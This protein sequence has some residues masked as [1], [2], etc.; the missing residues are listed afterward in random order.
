MSFVKYFLLT[1]LCVCALDAKADRIKSALKQLEKKEFKKVRESLDK[2]FE[3]D[4]SSAGASY[5]YAVFFV[6]NEN[7]AYNIDSAYF[8]INQAILFYPNTEEK[9]IEDWDKININDSSLNAQKLYI[10]KLAFQKAMKEN[11]VE[12]FQYFINNYS[13]ALQKNKAIEKRNELAWK[14]TAKENTEKSYLYFM[15]SY[16]QAKQFPEAKDLYDRFVIDRETQNKTL[17]AYENFVRKYPTNEHIKEAEWA[18]FELKTAEHNIIA[19]TKFINQYPNNFYVTRAYDWLLAFYDEE[20]NTSIFANQYPN[21][22]DKEFL[23]ER[24]KA[25]KQQYIPIWEEGQYVYIDQDGKASPIDYFSNIPEDH[26]CESLSENFFIIN[27]KRGK[28]LMDKTGKIVISPRFENVEYFDIGLYQVSQEGKVGLQHIQGYEILDDDFQAIELLNLNFLSYQKNNLWGLSTFNGKLLTKNKF[29][30]IFALGGKFI[31]FRKNLS[32]GVISNEW[33]RKNVTQENINIPTPYDSLALLSE[34]Y[35]MVYKNNQKTAFNLERKEV[36]SLTTFDIESVGFGWAIG[37][38]STG[39]QLFTEKGKQISQDTFNLVLGS[40]KY[41]VGKKMDKWGFFNSKGEL[42]KAFEYDTVFFFSEVVFYEKEDTL[43]AEFASTN[44]PLDFS[45]FE[46]FTLHF[47]ENKEVPWLLFAE[48]RYGK[49]QVFSPEGKALFEEKYDEVFW[50]E[51][52]FL[53]F[54]KNRKQG[55]LSLGGEVLLKPYFDGI[56]KSDE[57]HFGLLYARK[58]GLLRKR[59][60][61]YIKP[62]YDV[63]LQPYFQ[64]IANHMFIAQYNGYFGL[65]DEKENNLIPFD[66]DVIKPWTKETALVQLDYEWFFY[67]F[68]EETKENPEITFQEVEFIKESDEENIIVVLKDDTKYGAWSSI[69]G[70]LLPIEYDFVYNLGTQESPILVGERQLKKKN[71]YEIIYVNK[72]GKTIWTKNLPEED[73]LKI[74]CE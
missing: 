34:N 51:P 70:E 22:Y 44:E 36:L 10:E 1:F 69:Y 45:N 18:I 55:L 37:T 35:V 3:K 43:W 72:E 6:E 60:T 57:K 14:L 62:K 21:F 11:T 54:K 39:Y 20:F 64:N 2:E 5:V 4:S 63:L 61:L 9:V 67:D 46:D 15:Q 40:E 12:A 17:D 23:K 41:L 25:E 47:G 24:L 38:D 73:F 48:D 28:G 68:S 30:E 7:P 52:N 31:G 49:V 42:V 19:Y 56:S 74:V 8:F 29:D 66:F 50:T 59:D 71:Q 58:F 16:P 27:T 26:R 65:I 32:Y 13:T 33:L 53:T